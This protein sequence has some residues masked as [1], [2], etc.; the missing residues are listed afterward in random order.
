MKYP[1][2]TP[3]FQEVRDEAVLIKLKYLLPPGWAFTRSDPV[4]QVGGRQEYYAFMYR[5][6]AV[7][8]PTDTWEL[9]SSANAD[10]LRPPFVATF[11]SARGSGLPE[12]L[13][14]T[15]VNIHVCFAHIRERHREVDAVRKMAE[16]LGKQLP[17]ER[18]NVVVLGDF[19]LPPIEALGGLQSPL[20]ALIR[21]PLSTTV[22]GNLYDNLLLDPSTLGRPHRGSVRVDACG[23]L[24]MDWRYY[25]LTKAPGAGASAE[26][27]A[28]EKFKCAVELSD[29]C[30]VWAALS[31]AGSVTTAPSA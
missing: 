7:E 18:H 5:K 13:E 27:V 20:A 16:D 30:P 22:F 12:T 31:T 17:S 15:L 6:S 23:V 28:V 1:S 8:I 10:V 21:P 4:G 11:R 25:P 26:A 3:N 24:R 9:D 29:H 19:N 2:L 14:L